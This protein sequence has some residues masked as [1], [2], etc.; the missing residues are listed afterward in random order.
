MYINQ[1]LFDWKVDEQK[2]AIPITRSFYDAIFH[3]GTHL[4]GRGVSKNGMRM[5]E[6]DFLCSINQYTNLTRQDVFSGQTWFSAMNDAAET[7]NVSLQLCM[8]NPIHTLASTTMSKATNGRATRDNHAVRPGPPASYDLVY[9]E[10]LVL[11]WFSVKCF[12]YFGGM[13]TS[14]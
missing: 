6:Q 8:M 10:F 2:H 1:S 5:F 13:L 12:V 9:A 4:G 14:L 11:G 3:N 7:A